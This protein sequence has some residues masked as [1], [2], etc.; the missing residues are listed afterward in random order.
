V[1]NFF[2]KKKVNLLPQ[3]ILFSVL[4]KERIEKNSK[5]STSKMKSSIGIQIFAKE[6]NI[7]KNV[8]AVY[9]CVICFVSFLI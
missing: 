4:S 6:I 1:K 3:K 2:T 5:L 9:I 8:A 7:K